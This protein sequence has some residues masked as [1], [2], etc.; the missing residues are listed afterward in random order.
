MLVFGKIK[1]WIRK[2]HRYVFFFIKK[3]DKTILPS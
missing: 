3:K 1:E 2:D